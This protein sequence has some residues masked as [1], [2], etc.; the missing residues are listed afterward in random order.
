M[1]KDTNILRLL[2]HVE[3]LHFI[4]IMVSQYH[5]LMLL[6]TYCKRYISTAHASFQDPPFHRVL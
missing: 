4:T 2:Y 3:T 6:H 5:N 1:Y